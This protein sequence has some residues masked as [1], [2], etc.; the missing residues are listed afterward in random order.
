M[1]I[2][3]LEFGLHDGSHCFRVHTKIW[4]R[5]CQLLGRESQTE[6]GLDF[7]TCCITNDL[8]GPGPV[9][10]EKDMILTHGSEGPEFDVI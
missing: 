9:F 6:V 5:R 8:N 3:K 7:K 1:L 4:R 10:Y 2:K